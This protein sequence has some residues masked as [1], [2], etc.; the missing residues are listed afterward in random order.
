MMAATPTTPVRQ[1]K[2]QHMA[3][4][5]NTELIIYCIHRCG[6]VGRFVE[7]EDVFEEA[8]RVAPSRFG[9]R[10]R[11]LPSD[12]AAD[13]ALRDALKGRGVPRDPHLL[14]LSPNRVGIQLTAEGVAF[15][16]QRMPHFEGLV[17]NKAPA[18]SDRP[19]QRHLVALERSEIVR[20][21]AA[22]DEMEATR[23]RFADLMRLTPDADSRA[24]RERLESYRSAAQQAGRQMSLDFLA[25]LEREHPDWFE[26]SR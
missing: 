23:V 6:G 14:I 24:W 2:G 21:Y 5:S 16:Q 8:F 19:S 7:I 20:G 10:S 11:N 15:V 3:E 22:G 4:T 12:K 9:W 1:R 26:V 13:Q 25:R 17:V 18:G